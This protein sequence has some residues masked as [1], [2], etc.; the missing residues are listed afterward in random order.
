MIIVDWKCTYLHQ[1]CHKLG[2]LL[3]WSYRCSNIASIVGEKARDTPY[4]VEI[5]IP[6]EKY[7][8]IQFTLAK[9]CGE[10]KIFSIQQHE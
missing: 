4:K 10:H 5:T 7:N 6:V 1:S 8:P 3:R 2:L 9:M